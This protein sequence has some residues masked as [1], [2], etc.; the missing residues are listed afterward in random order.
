VEKVDEIETGDL[1]HYI[2]WQAVFRPDKNFTKIR[3]VNDA[4]AKTGKNPSLNDCL[5][6]G[7]DLNTGLISMLLNCRRH[8]ILVIMDIEKAFLMTG[9][10]PKDRDA[11][12]FLWLDD[13]S[14]PP[15]RHNIQ[16][17]RFCRVPFGVITSPYLLQATIEHAF[18][19]R[20]FKNF[21]CC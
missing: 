17:L 14:K 7:T 19:Q 10:A 6:K 16:I 18:A 2:P 13:T 8:S 3:L 15:S 12:R 1:C 4:S 20:F 21:S 9:I 11:L 5:Y